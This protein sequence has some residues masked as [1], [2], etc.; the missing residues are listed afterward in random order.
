MKNNIR[1]SLIYVGV[2]AAL[3]A[4]YFTAQVFEKEMTEQLKND[5]REAAQLIEVAY[6]TQN[7]SGNESDAPKNKE[8]LSAFENGSLRITLIDVDGKVL[9][10]SDAESASMENHKNR[11]EVVDAFAK[12]FGENLRYSITLNAKVFYYAK[13]LSD[14][15]VLRLGRRQAN[16]HESISKTMPYLFALLAVVVVVSIL[17]AIG[18]ARAFVRPVQ[19]LAENLGQPELMDDEGVYEEIAPLVKTIR[20]QNREL[21]LTVEQLSAE[22]KKTAQMR[23]EFTANASH[24]LKTPLTSISGYAELIENGMAKTE[25]VKLFAGKIHKEANRLLSIANDIMTLSKLDAPGDTALDLNENIEL[26]Q[27]ASN[28]VDELSLNA[29]KK[30]VSLSLEGDETATVKGNQRLLFEMLYNLVDNAIRYTEQGGNVAIEVDP[31]SLTVKDNGIGIPEENQPRIFERFYRVDKSRS[32]ATGGTGLG[33][34]IVK[35]IAEVHHA[36]ISLQSQEGKGTEICVEF[37]QV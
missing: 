34:A 30:G 32:K 26:W 1:F 28:C 23:D 24:E 6:E 25:D 9:Y 12:G 18:L 10:E 15:N 7:L 5:L 2:L 22:K 11:P 13:R 14:G 27:V 33:L 3:F 17:I 31:R 29:E 35:H 20:K 8:S 37:P 16:L 4:V 36:K 19:K 21:Q